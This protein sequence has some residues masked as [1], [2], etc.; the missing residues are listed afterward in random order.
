MFDFQQWRRWLCERAEELRKQGFTV[1]LRLSDSGPKPATA[2]NLDG[3]QVI[4]S[5]T[6]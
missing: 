2:L 6:N 1:E 3:Q 4:A 5:F